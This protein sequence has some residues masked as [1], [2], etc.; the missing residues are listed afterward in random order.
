[1][2]VAIVGSQDPRVP[3]NGVNTHSRVLAEALKELNVDVV[4]IHPFDEAEPNVLTAGRKVWHRL[5]GRSERL[6]AEWRLRRQR[7]AQRLSAVRVD[8]LHLQDPI[9]FAAARDARLTA[10]KL[11]VYHG[12]DLPGNEIALRYDLAMDSSAVLAFRDLAGDAVSHADT[13]VAV[14]SWAAERIGSL[15]PLARGPIRVISNAVPTK[16]TPELATDVPAH[17]VLTV[18]Q[19]V[20]RKGPDVWLDAARR[21][22]DELPG[23]PFVWVG[24]GGARRASQRIA[25]SQ[26]MTGWV[27]LVGGRTDVHPYLASAQLFVLPSRTENLPMALLEAMAHGL[28]CVATAVGG[29]AE[30]IEPGRT[31]ILVPPED[32]VALADAILELLRKPAWAKTLGEN[33]AAK[34]KADLSARA[35]AESYRREYDQL[36]ASAFASKARS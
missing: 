33:A 4:S 25:Q 10:P 30:V 27:H 31:G 1:M 7:L 17:A 11:L 29:V 26:G 15:R 34:I 23:V 20:R 32:P 16:D 21:V 24:E 22:H 8:V 5:L 12:Y 36:H 28:P 35:M 18:G 3:S 13:V 14:S 6:L 2:R 19:V 9:A